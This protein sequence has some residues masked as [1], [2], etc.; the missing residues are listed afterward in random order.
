MDGRPLTNSEFYEQLIAKNSARNDE[1]KE[2][3][4]LLLGLSAISGFREIELTQL[5]IGLFVAPTCELLSLVIL[6]ESISY[7]GYERPVPLDNETITEWFTE[8]LK[9]LLNS[10]IH[11]QAGKSY[12]GLNPNAQLFVNDDYKPF[13]LQKRGNDRLNPDQ[14]NKKLDNL[15]KHAG[16]WGNGVRRKSFIRTCTINYYRYGLSVDEISI[17][18]G[19]SEPTIKNALAMDIGQYSVINE[20]FEERKA[21]IARRQESF[22]K[23]RRFMI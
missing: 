19:Q 5:T 20:W 9:W 13:T 1:F 17:I 16:L 22:K 8:H 7:D 6:P 12:L 21:K 14:M 11:T 10:G 3:N 15:I 23:R 18:T 4:K 2:Q